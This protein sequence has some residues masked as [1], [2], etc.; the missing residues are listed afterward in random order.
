MV[1]VVWDH[2]WSS[3]TTSPRAEPAPKGGSFCPGKQLIPEGWGSDRLIG[4]KVTEACCAQVSISACH[5]AQCH[6]DV[7]E[8]RV[9]LQQHRKQQ[10]KVQTCPKWTQ[11]QPYPSPDLNSISGQRW[12]FLWH[13]IRALR[14]ESPYIS[15]LFPAPPVWETAHY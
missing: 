11:S 12:K 7:P 13:L 9:L 5:L 2:P 4:D 10:C 1:L 14:N 15:C 6:A 8:V 3:L